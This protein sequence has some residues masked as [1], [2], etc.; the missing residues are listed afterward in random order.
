M[1]GTIAETIGVLSGL[2]VGIFGSIMAYK[3]VMRA[4]KLD[5]QNPK[6]VS[7]GWLML[8]SELKLRVAE[9]EHKAEALL[10]VSERKEQR[11]QAAEDKADR[12]VNAEKHCVARLTLVEQRVAEL[13]L[14]V[15]PK[16]SS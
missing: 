13:E 6:S 11:L 4:R 3:T 15:N 2:V 9:A 1:I 5:N 14:T 16:E 7:E 8:Y 12:A 10:L